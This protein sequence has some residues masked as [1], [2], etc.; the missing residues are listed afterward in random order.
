MFA[1]KCEANFLWHPVVHHSLLLL[2]TLRQRHTL[3][4]EPSCTKTSRPDEFW[5]LSQAGNYFSIIATSN[6]DSVSLERGEEEERGSSLL[7]ISEGGLHRLHN[8][9]H[10]FYFISSSMF[11]EQ[12]QQLQTYLDTAF[13]TDHVLR[14][15]D[16]VLL[17]LSTDEMEMTRQMHS[18]LMDLVARL[19]AF[20]ESDNDDVLQETEKWSTWPLFTT[21]KFLVEEAGLLLGP[22]P[23]VAKAYRQL[24]G[25][26]PV[27][28]H[29]RLVNRTVNLALSGEGSFVQPPAW[30]YRGFLR[31][32]QRK[33]ADY[34]TD[35]AERMMEGVLGEKGPLKARVSG[36]RF[37]L[38]PVSARMPWTM[39]REK[40]GRS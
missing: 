3:V 8:P 36:A 24:Q 4:L 38:Q 9:Q 40:M 21:L 30:P 23:R 29:T 7:H 35:P 17:A 19:E 5:R 13:V 11:V 33:L 2:R 6:S 10:I 31:E 1:V 26:N 32:V 12:K 14:A 22:F 28:A 18:N 27:V 16:D 37:G 25:S 15:V 20:L 34:T 39:Q